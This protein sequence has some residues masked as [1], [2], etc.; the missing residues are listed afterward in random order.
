MS[1]G[2]FDAL[3]DESGSIYTVNR[4]HLLAI[5]SFPVSVKR[6]SECMMNSRIICTKFATCRRHEFTSR[7]SRY[8]P[9]VSTAILFNVP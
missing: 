7:L 3:Y 8:I 1:G 6:Y 4:L 9:I 2:G 5:V